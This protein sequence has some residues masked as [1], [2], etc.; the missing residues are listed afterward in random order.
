MRTAR[1]L[2]QDLS[3]QVLRGNENTK[4]TEL[5]YNTG[6]VTKQCLFVCIRGASF[7]SHKAAGEV[8]KKGAAVLVAERP[9]DV[10][11]GVTVLLVK[12]TRYALALISAAYFHYPA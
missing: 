3:Y 10:P 6:K 11:E 9:V 2:L 5:V 12:N 7:D 4:V 1:E 8:A